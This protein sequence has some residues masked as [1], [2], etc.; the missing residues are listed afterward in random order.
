MPRFYLEFAKKIILWT[1]K[2]G[3]YFSAFAILFEFQTGKY[4]AHL[5]FVGRGVAG[6]TCFL[7]TEREQVLNSLENMQKS[8]QKNAK[9][10]NQNIS[11]ILLFRSRIYDISTSKILFNAVLQ[12]GYLLCKSV[13]MVISFNLFIRISISCQTHSFKLFFS[14]S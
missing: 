14:K 2:L 11:D 9:F 8:T 12:Q 10:G 6:L 7:S 4:E 5:G 1:N 13:L 3:K